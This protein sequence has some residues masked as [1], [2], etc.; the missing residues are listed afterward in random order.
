MKTSKIFVLGSEFSGTTALGN[1]LNN[2]YPG[3]YVGESRSLFESNKISAP[4]S[5]CLKCDNAS[6]NCPIYS[7]EK[8]ASYL[9]G[10]PADLLNRLAENNG[11]GVVID[12]SKEPGYLSKHFNEFEEESN[13]RA[14]IVVRN[15]IRTISSK[16][17]LRVNEFEW[18]QEFENWRNRYWDILRTVNRLAIPHI[19]FNTEVLRDSQLSNTN[20]KRA[21]RNLVNFLDLDKVIQFKAN[22]DASPTHQIGGN[23]N[24]QSGEKFKLEN[25]LRVKIKHSQLVSS[26]HDTPLFLD[27]ANLL[28]LSLTEYMTSCSHDER[29][30]QLIELLEA[31]NDR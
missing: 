6:L 26:A 31:T 4:N 8:L 13:V 23:P 11:L 29:M 14:I 1:V 28:G 17:D 30:Q 12:G 22:I 16:L 21:L 9:N 3:L 5:F 24:T 10:S 18:I 2:M 19:L 7:A 25:E 20:T 27:L 15:P